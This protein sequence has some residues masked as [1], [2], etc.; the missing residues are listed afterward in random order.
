MISQRDIPLEKMFSFELAPIS[1]AIFD[2]YGGLS[3]S[4]KAQ[5]RYTLA[6][7]SKE[8]TDPEE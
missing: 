4:G 7:W 3:K 6:K 5:M 8:N 2:E 1:S